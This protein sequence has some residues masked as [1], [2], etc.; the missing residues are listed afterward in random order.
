MLS[1]EVRTQSDTVAAPALSSIA[2]HKV[3]IR[4][5]VPARKGGAGYG[6]APVSA[7]PQ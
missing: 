6:P 2:C 7:E 3:A 1:N 4:H 5:S